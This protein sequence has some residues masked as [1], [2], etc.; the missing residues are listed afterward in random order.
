LELNQLTSF[1]SARLE[2]NGVRIVDC[3]F[4]AWEA[5]DYVSVSEPS[6][7]GVSF[8]GQLCSI[9]LDGRSL[10][11]PVPAG[12]VATIGPETVEWLRVRSPSRQIEITAEPWLRAEI[13]EELGVWTERDLA[14]LRLGFDPVLWTIAARLR[15]AARGG[16]PLEP[17][18]VEALTRRAYGRVFEA[19][20][21]GRSRERG[22]GRLD[23][24]RLQRVIAY[25]EE[26]LAERFGL[27]ELAREA[28]L[29]PFHF[30]RSFRRTVGVTPHRYVV[31]RRVERAHQLLA[32][33][34]ASIPAVSE[35]VGYTNP[36]HLRAA[37]RRHIGR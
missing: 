26:H 4:P 33:A 29:S 7:I 27:A 15:G 13:A 19:A 8:T 30:V 16:A 25:V 14:D 2:A 37:I 5:G 17:I 20:F 24:R 10:E 23:E 21:R 34:G 11:R 35:A 22:T 31:M 12:A 28:A 18:E 9:R 36:S 1:D 32:Q 6:S 3:R